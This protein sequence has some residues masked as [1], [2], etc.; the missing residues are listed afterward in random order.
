[1]YKI[2][3]CWNKKA[4][5]IGNNMFLF[6]HAYSC[7][8]RCEKHRTSVGENPRWVRFHRI[9]VYTCKQSNI[10]CSCCVWPHGNGLV[11]FYSLQKL[12]KLCFSLFPIDN[13]SAQVLKV[14]MI[15]FHGP[16]KFINTNVLDQISP[17]IDLI[18]IIYSNMTAY[19][20]S[21]SLCRYISTF[22]TIGCLRRQNFTWEVAETSVGE[23]PRWVCFHRIFVYTCKQSNIMCSCCVWPCI[24]GQYEIWTTWILYEWTKQKL[25]WTKECFWMILKHLI[26]IK[27]NQ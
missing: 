20:S 2:Q 13:L 14:V 25:E 27:D 11:G 24:W 4:T 12:F 15:F 7:E 8:G 21:T 16:L 17:I 26:L 19:I 18:F 1:M 22:S 5:G 3:Y 10:M 6:P 9:F 23:N